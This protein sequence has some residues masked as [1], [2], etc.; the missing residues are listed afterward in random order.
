MVMRSLAEVQ[1]NSVDKAVIYLGGD[2]SDHGQ[3]HGALSRVRTMEGVLLIGLIRASRTK[4]V[5]MMS[6]Y[7]CMHAWLIV[8][9][10][11]SCITVGRP[12]F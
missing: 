7:A 12:R 9:F 4:A 8:L 6:I 11:D 2:I 5:R 10:L 3:A 1:G